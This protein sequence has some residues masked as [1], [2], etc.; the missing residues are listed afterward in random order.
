MKEK[1]LYRK[2]TFDRLFMTLSKIK[3][4]TKNC[5]RFVCPLTKEQRDLFEAFGIKLP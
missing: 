5:E 4:V 3:T 2:M 1:D